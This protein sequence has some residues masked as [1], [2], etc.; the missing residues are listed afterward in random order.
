MAT[1]WLVVVS[2]NPEWDIR[3]VPTVVAGLDAVSWSFR[4]REPSASVV[5][6]APLFVA[7][8]VCDTLAEVDWV[9]ETETLAI[10]LNPPN[11]NI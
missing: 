4:D 7:V 6:T 11:E 2:T 1:G 8:E 9:A 5:E 3:L 10:L